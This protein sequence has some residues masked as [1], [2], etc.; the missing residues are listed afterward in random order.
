MYETFLCPTL[1]KVI[2]FFLIVLLYSELRELTHYLF[3]SRFEPILQF[4][5]VFF[6]TVSV[7][8]SGPMSDVFYVE[9]VYSTTIEIR[10]DTRFCADCLKRNSRW[11][12]LAWMQATNALLWV[13]FVSCLLKTFL[14]KTGVEAVL[15]FLRTRV[16]QVVQRLGQLFLRPICSLQLLSLLVSSLIFGDEQPLSKTYWL[17]NRLS[18]KNYVCILWNRL[19]NS[20]ANSKNPLKTGSYL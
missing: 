19:L 11:D 9:L 3:F 8:M 14:V 5:S 20:R 16:Y 15:S 4:S 2:S 7:V 12:F 17:R 1:L 6:R 18:S 13:K 10:K